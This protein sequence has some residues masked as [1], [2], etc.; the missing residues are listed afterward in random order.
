MIGV[1]KIDVPKCVC[2]LL[3]KVFNDWSSLNRCSKSMFLFV[4]FCFF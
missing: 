4:F 2:V 3:L 1:L